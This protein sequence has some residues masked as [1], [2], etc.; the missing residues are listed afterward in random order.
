MPRK[1]R[2]SVP[3]SVILSAE[4]KALIRNVAARESRTFSHQVRYVIGQWCDQQRKKETKRGKEGEKGQE[5]GQKG[6]EVGA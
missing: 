4:D 5:V 3:T 6:E 2:T 1:P